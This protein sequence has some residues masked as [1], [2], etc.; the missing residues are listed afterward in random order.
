MAL[1]P[2]RM[3]GLR[4]ALGKSED[5]I[6]AFIGQTGA[7]NQAEQESTVQLSAAAKIRDAALAKGQAAYDAVESKA[8]ADLDAARANATRDY[9]VVATVYGAKVEEAAG[10]L[11]QAETA[12]RKLQDEIRD[13]YG[14][15]TNLFPTSSRGVGSTI[16]VG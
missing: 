4:K 6:T 8:K 1:D 7:L 9:T 13:E 14:Y 10:A 3:R 5:L 15:N 2:S 16:K 12:L 11:K